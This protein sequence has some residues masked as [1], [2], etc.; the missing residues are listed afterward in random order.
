MCQRLSIPP[1]IEAIFDKPGNSWSGEDV[2]T[3]QTWFNVEPQ[4]RC[5]LLYTAFNLGKVA[6]HQDAEDTWSRFNFR[7]LANGKVS[8][9]LRDNVI[10]NFNS[11]KGNFIGWL[12]KGLYF[13]C[14]DERKRLAKIRAKEEPL[15]SHEIH[16]PDKSKLN[17]SH[18]AIEASDDEQSIALLRCIEALPEKYQIVVILY[19]FNDM[20]AESIAAELGLS[21]SN[22]KTRLFRSRQRIAVCLDNSKIGEQS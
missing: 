22:V 6:T 2:D 7:E 10:T 3:V 4:L 18:F 16:L 11:T 15:E 9:Y 14:L 5:M 13:F 21:I 19:Y 17:D 12:K 8:S 20:S 1:N